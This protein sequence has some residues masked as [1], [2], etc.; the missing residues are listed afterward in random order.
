MH[1]TGGKT[2]YVNP[3]ESNDKKLPKD[4]LFFYSSIR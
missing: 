3:H 4:H 2:S 1:K